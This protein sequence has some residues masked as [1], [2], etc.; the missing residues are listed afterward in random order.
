M[1]IEIV[2]GIDCPWCYLRKRR[3]EAALEE[4]WLSGDFERGEDLTDVEVSIAAAQDT[5]WSEVRTRA[6]RADEAP[7][8][9]VRDLER[10]LKSLGISSVSTFSC[11]RRWAPASAHDTRVLVEAID[12][13]NAAGEVPT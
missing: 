13:A 3:L 6:A 9:Q 2:S 12:R 1:P 10:E 7:W 11:D 4:R 5:G 8:A